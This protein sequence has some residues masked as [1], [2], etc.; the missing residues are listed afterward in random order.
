M[1]VMFVF[2]FVFNEGSHH[3]RRRAQLTCSTRARRACFVTLRLLWDDWRAM[4]VSAWYRCQG[5]QPVHGTSAPRPAAFPPV[6]VP[7]TLFDV[8]YRPSFL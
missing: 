1:F 6:L 7:V 5:P 3:P 2:A 8:N 4:A